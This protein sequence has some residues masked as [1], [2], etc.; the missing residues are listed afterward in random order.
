M[1]VF[2]EMLA[3]LKYR[4]FRF[5]VMSPFRAVVVLLVST[6]VFSSLSRRFIRV[7][8][9][10]FPLQKL[11]GLHHKT[12]MESRGNP[13]TNPEVRDNFIVTGTSK[14]FVSSHGGSRVQLSL[15]PFFGCILGATKAIWAR[16]DLQRK[17]WARYFASRTG[18]L[19][20]Y[21]KLQN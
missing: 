17:Q 15:R 5:F 18:W 2:L 19:N 6:Y 16:F 14:V 20:T 7:F 10:H 1:K 4:G 12:G 9:S 11:P 8:S 3:A 21:K 13:L